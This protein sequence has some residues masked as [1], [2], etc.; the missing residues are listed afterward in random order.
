MMTLLTFLF[1][2]SGKHLLRAKLRVSKSGKIKTE[3]VLA[4][5]TQLFLELVA[6]ICATDLE[7][8]TS[9]D[10]VKMESPRATFIVFWLQIVRN[11]QSKCK[12]I[13]G[14]E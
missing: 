7:I 8:A 3:A 4:L 2:I 5:I 6:G 14:L 1:L 9:S 11:L 12:Q 10:Q 13:S